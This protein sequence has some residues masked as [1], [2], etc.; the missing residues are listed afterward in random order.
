MELTAD[1][2]APQLS[3]GASL[4]QLAIESLPGSVRGDVQAAY[5][6]ARAR[7]TDP[8]AVG[9]LAMMLHAYEQYRAARDCY[10]I[11]LQHDPT[12]AR[13]TYLSG[14]V[15]AELGEQAAAAASFRLAL[16][17]DPDYLPGRVRLADALMQGGD[18]S[19][20]REEYAALA[21]D[22]PELA[23]AHYGLGRLSSIG[24]EPNAAVEH[25]QRVVKLAPRFGP[26]H[27]ALATRV[28]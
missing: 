13:W 16:R 10:R 3:I 7:P 27:Y 21:R 26:A 18:L 5:D 8:S 28:P 17:L 24:G 12:S 9:G 23:L 14:V 11:V 20:S 1:A 22:L 2:V 15:Q 19:A 6:A 25:Y 4:P